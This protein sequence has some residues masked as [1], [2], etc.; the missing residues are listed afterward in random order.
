VDKLIKIY[1]KWCDDHKYPQLSADELI[2]ELITRRN[3][4]EED[5]KWIRFWQEK[6]RILEQSEI[7]G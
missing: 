5:I 2:V 3:E 4:L 6:L 1:Q 7:N